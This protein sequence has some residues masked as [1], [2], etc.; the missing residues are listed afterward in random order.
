MWDY[1]EVMSDV[2]IWSGGVG[3][4]DACEEAAA[5]LPHE[6]CLQRKRHSLGLGSFNYSG[7]HGEAT[8]D[9]LLDSESQD[10]LG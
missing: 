8:P 9:L 5:M 7:I 4:R 3:C 1:A 10:V 2:I 6:G